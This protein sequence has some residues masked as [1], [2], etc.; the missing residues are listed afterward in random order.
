MG[1]A[2]WKG[3]QP[4]ACMGHAAWHGL[5]GADTCKQAFDVQTLSR[6]YIMDCLASNRVI[7]LAAATATPEVH[8]C[9]CSLEQT[10]DVSC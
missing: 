2:S 5:D 9:P 4:S 8:A 10:K 3:V 6:Y 7:G 1:G